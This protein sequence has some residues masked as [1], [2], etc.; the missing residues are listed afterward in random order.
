[1]SG[2]ERSEQSEP[3]NLVV[4]QGFVLDLIC[5]LFSLAYASSGF[6]VKRLTAITVKIKLISGTVMPTASEG[7]NDAA[8][9]VGGIANCIVT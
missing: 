5:V 9:D 2:G 8:F 3:Q 1:V 7:S 6:R 4:K